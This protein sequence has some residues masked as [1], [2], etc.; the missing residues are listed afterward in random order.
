MTNDPDGANRTEGWCPKCGLRLGHLTVSLTGYCELHGHVAAE[1]TRPY[2]RWA[3][4]AKNGELYAVRDT[5][6]LA[7]AALKD[8]ARWLDEAYSSAHPAAG[9]WCNEREPFRIEPVTSAYEAEL[10]EELGSPVLDRE[11]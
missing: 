11:P 1:F 6:E 3:V 9:K 5:E 10:R 4:F 2:Q 7:G 8:A